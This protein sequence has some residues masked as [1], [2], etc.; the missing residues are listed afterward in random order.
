[1]ANQATLADVALLAEVSLSTASRALG[2]GHGRTV[3]PELRARVRAAAA[4]LSY[5]P[6]AHAQAMR[7][8]SSTIGLIV[9]DILDPFAAT[10]AAGVL[11]AARERNLLV[12]IA[13]TGT[14]PDTEV[15]LVESLRRQRASAVILVGSRFADSAAQRWL[16]EEIAA[17]RASGGQVVVVGQDQL[18]APAIVIDNAEGADHLARVLWSQGYRRFA[19][20]AGPESMLTSDERVDGFRAG[21]SSVGYELP[22]ENVIGSAM[23]RDGGHTAMSELLHHE[24]DVECVFAVND[25]MAVGAMAALRDQRLSVPQDMAVAGFG[26][27][28]ALRDIQPALTTVRL[29]LAAIGRRALEMASMANTPDA[30]DGSD[31][32]TSRP[33]VVPIRGEVVVRASTPARLPSA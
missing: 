18:N 27:I 8:A 1:M 13:S 20:L 5:S 7:S 19:V 22:D 26:D 2:Q 4:E 3:G 15:Q 16:A 6:N 25:V 33:M 11:E 32:V 29:P 28:A 10:I 24:I 12:S 14:D 31:E 17:I 23:T 30:P 9:H 21:L